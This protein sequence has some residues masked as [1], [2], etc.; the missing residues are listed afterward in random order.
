M[1]KEVPGYTYEWF[2]LT[3]PTEALLQIVLEVLEA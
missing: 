1:T 2:V 3:I